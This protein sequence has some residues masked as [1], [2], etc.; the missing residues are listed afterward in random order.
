MF[1]RKKEK[2]HLLQKYNLHKKRLRFHGKKENCTFSKIFSGRQC[3][4]GKRKIALF[5]IF[6]IFFRFLM[7]KY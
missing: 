3:F 7:E 5:S 1:S 2:L 6:F 4:H